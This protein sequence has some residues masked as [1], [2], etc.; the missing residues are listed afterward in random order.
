[1][2]HAIG[3]VELNSIA[4]GIETCDFMVKAAQV[5]LLRASTICPGKYVVIVGGGV[6]DVT[7]SMR[8]GTAHAA[9]HLVDKL[10]ISNVHEQ[11]IPAVFMTT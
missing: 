5:E 4:R 3:M 6:G 7:A 9:E 1:M 8:E 10:L 2:R 11:L